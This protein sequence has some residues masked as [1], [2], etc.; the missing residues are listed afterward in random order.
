MYVYR[1]GGGGRV[2]RER[3]TDFKELVHMIVELIEEGGKSKIC[4]LPREELQLGLK[5]V[6]WQNSLFFGGDQSLFLGSS[7]DQ[8]RSTHI[9]KGN[10]LYSMS[11]D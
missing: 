8:M 1:E 7:V 11:T 10:L 4:S 2:G 6:C 9:I 5:A 3:L